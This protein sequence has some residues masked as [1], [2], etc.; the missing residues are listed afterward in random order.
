MKHYITGNLKII[1]I[2]PDYST[3]GVE[4]TMYL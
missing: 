4:E 1:K 2:S 3:T